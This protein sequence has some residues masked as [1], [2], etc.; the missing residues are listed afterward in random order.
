[1]EKHLASVFHFG[2]KDN[3]SNK[4]ADFMGNNHDDHL[5]MGIVDLIKGSDLDDSQKGNL[6]S[7]GKNLKA[8]TNGSSGP[9]PGTKKTGFK[10]GSG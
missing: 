7:K 4:V 6:G 3:N 5:N 10:V 8:A 1:M 2:K 9:K